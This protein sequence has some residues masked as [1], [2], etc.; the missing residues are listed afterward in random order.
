MAFYLEAGLKFD[1]M[2][3]L[4]GLPVIGNPKNLALI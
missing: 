3:K 4:A 1:V 2:E